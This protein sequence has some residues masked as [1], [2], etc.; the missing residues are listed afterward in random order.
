LK[1]SN[2][3]HIVETRRG[4]GL[5]REAT[6]RVASTNGRDPRSREVIT[7]IPYQRFCMMTLIS[8]M[9]VCQIHTYRYGHYLKE[10]RVCRP[11]SQVIL[12]RRLYLSTFLSHVLTK[13]IMAWK[14]SPMS[15]T[16]ISGPKL[17]RPPAWF[18]AALC[19]RFVN[20]RLKMREF[21]NERFIALA[22]APR[23]R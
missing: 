18:K 7:W 9:L 23:V 10:I 20:I 1:G 15:S 13:V 12:R 3:R 22:N 21:A 4:G 17:R 6:R 14:T 19:K 8:I 2:P 16:G 5:W 11:T